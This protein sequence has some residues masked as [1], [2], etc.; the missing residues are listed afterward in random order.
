MPPHLLP[1]VV[2]RRFAFAAVVGLSI[3]TCDTTPSSVTPDHLPDPY[4]VELTGSRN[5]WRV[6]HPVRLSRT[7]DGRSR[8][9][10]EIRVPFRRKIVLVLRSE[11][12]VYMLGLP[13]LR[14]KELAVPSLEFRMELTPRRPGR[15]EIVEDELC[16]DPRGH[17]LRSLVI[18]PEEQ[19]LAEFGS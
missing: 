16:G 7:G 4:L 18:E 17:V 15:F 6:Q 3:L 13:E 5:G 8:P 12:Y 2:A 9:L 19:F 11:D 14:K 10:T 1:V